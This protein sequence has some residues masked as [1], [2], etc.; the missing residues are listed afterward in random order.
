[1]PSAW[2]RHRQRHSDTAGHRVAPEP[3]AHQRAAIV[4]RLIEQSEQLDLFT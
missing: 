4:A 2:C 1:M 3:M